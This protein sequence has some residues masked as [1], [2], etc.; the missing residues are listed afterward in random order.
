MKEMSDLRPV[1][2]ILQL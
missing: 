2:S 1:N